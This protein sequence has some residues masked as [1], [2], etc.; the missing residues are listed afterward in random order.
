MLRGLTTVTYYA[1]DLEAARRWYTELLGAE[2]YFNREGPDGRPAYVEFRIGDY[3]HEL[4]LI[5]SRYAPWHTPE[6]PAGV[7]VYWHV[8]DVHAAFER[9]LAMG[10]K[11]HE[12]PVDRGE[13]FVTASVTDPFGN[14]L[15]VMENPHYLDVLG[16]IRRA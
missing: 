12:K 14:L 16:S 1:D 11:E 9:L 15:G 13:G 2:P 8:D 4:G 10:A 5:S 7:I 6:R 3:Q